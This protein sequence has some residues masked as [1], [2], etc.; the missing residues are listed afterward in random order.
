MCSAWAMT[1]P[2]ASKIAV[3]QSWRSL[4][5][6]E[7]EALIKAKETSIR[8]VVIN[9][10]ARYGTPALMK[11]L[12]NTVV[13]AFWVGVASVA[14]GA[15]FVVVHYGTQRIVVRDQRVHPIDG[16]ELLGQGVRNAVVARG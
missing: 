5:F 8:L 3:E 2:W 12:W 16:D 15:P 13:L 14:V 7:Y 10:L 9:G 11:A 4:I 1:S 6:E